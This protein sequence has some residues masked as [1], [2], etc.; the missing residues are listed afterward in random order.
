MSHHGTLDGNEDDEEIEA[1]DA[2]QYQVSFGKNHIEFT[3]GYHTVRKEATDS[4]LGVPIISD[5]EIRTIPGSVVRVVYAG[6]QNAGPNQGVNREKFTDSDH[7]KGY[8]SAL[9]CNAEDVS[10]HALNGHA[11]ITGQANTD[12]QDQYQPGASAHVHSVV[13]IGPHIAL[14]CIA[15]RREDGSERTQ[16]EI[17][18]ETSKALKEAGFNVNE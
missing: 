10:P 6:A 15:R 16:S 8:P 7:T 3:T 13:T 12:T 4:F 1:M 14:E 2:D 9:I 17:Q 5:V 18:T 11:N